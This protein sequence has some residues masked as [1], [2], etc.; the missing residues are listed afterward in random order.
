MVFQMVNRMLGV[1]VAVTVSTT[2]AAH[3]ME[4]SLRRVSTPA[5]GVRLPATPFSLRPADAVPV[6]IRS[7]LPAAIQD[8]A[9]TVAT[10]AQSVT[11]EARTVLDPKGAVTEAYTRNHDALESLRTQA[12]GLTGERKQA[13]DAAITGDEQQLARLERRALDYASGDALAAGGEM[14]GVVAHAKATVA[15]QH[16]ATTD[17][18]QHSTDQRRTDEGQR[19]SDQSQPR[20]DQSKPRGGGGGD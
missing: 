7:S 5:V 1:V 10:Q 18:K 4:D 12:A 11:T 2:V 14:D 20:S 6:A 17:E 15:A 3:A 9:L 8:A 16:P 13:A 19:H